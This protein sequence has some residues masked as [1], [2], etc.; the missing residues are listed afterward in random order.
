MCTHEQRQE[1]PFSHTALSLALYMSIQMHIYRLFM[2]SSHSVYPY[3]IKHILF[4][5]K[6]YFLCIIHM[7]MYTY[8]YVCICIQGAVFA[9]Y[10]SLF[11]H[12]YIYVQINTHIYAVHIDSLPPMLLSLQIQGQLL[13]L[14]DLYAH[15]YTYLYT[16]IHTETV[17]LS[18][19]YTALSCYTHMH[20]LHVCINI[21]TYILIYILNIKYVLYRLF[22]YL[23]VCMYTQ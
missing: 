7:P 20:T 13:T 1:E 16:F 9:G 19:N 10:S 23:Q 22:I 21:H 6:H 4:T 3:I 12:K 5:Q 17:V 2:H 11:L 15:R 14:P 18:H 8:V